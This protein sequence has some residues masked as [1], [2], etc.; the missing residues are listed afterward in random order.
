VDQSRK[1]KSFR[2]V[3]KTFDVSTNSIWRWQKLEEEQGHF[4]NRPLNRKHKKVGPDKVIKYIFNH[5][6]EYASE[7]AKNFKVQPSSI[8]YIL[9]NKLNFVRKKTASLSRTR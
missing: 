2:E 6:D 1:G 3:A 9:K 5:K 4:K 8:L 7:V